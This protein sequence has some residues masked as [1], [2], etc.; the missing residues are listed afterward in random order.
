MTLTYYDPKE[1]M[2]P[3]LRQATVVLAPVRVGVDRRTGKII[4]GWKHVMQSMMVIFSTRFHERVLRR[5]FGSFVPHILGENAIERVITRFYWAV[6][7]AIDMW[8]PNYSI[9]RVAVVR[10]IETDVEQTL[11]SSEELRMGQLTVRHDGVYRPRGHLGDITPESRRIVGLI[12][13]SDHNWTS[14]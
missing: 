8:E 6:A 7:G 11:T 5:W 4:V 12:R 1:D 14:L 2:W 10:R 3:E 9:T 13:S